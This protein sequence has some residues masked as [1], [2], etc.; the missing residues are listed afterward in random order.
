MLLKEADCT[1]SLH[2][3]CLCNLSCNAAD[4]S[5]NWMLHYLLNDVS[6]AGHAELLQSKAKHHRPALDRHNVRHSMSI[7]NVSIHHNCRHCLCDKV[8][9]CS[10]ILP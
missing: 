8:D 1:A 5:P 9:I 7:A 4:T 2:V 3:E 6:Y 10:G